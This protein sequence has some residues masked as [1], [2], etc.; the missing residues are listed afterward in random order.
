MHILLFLALFLMIH[1]RRRMTNNDLLTCLASPQVK[2]NLTKLKS[3]ISGYQSRAQLRAG[4]VPGSEDLTSELMERGILL[5]NFLPDFWDMIEAY[6][7]FA[8]KGP[9]IYDTSTL[10]LGFWT[11]SPYIDMEL[12]SIQAASLHNPF[13]NHPQC[14]HHKWMT[15]RESGGLR[16]DPRALWSSSTFPRRRTSTLPT[17]HGTST[18]PW[19]T[20]T[21]HTVTLR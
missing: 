15:P 7:V 5:I 8:P 1:R 4:L 6:H 14:G 16:Q 18:G 12:L 9:S 19:R 10:F 13:G 11:P 20:G 3:L 17:T 2:N 21:E